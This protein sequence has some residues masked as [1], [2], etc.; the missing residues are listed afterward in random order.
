MSEQAL[1]IG[2]QLRF[3]ARCS[4][5]H[6][7]VDYEVTLCGVRVPPLSGDIRV[8]PGVF[9]RE[10]ASR[11]PVRAYACDKCRATAD[12]R[13]IEWTLCEQNYGY[14]ERRGP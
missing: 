9:R 7:T 14:I 1:P 13:G 5:L 11:R 6:L 3:G 12:L 8:G 2:W 10:W 4:P